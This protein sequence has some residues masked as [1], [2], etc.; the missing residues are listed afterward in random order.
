[1]RRREFL[2]NKMVEV[3]EE[4]GMNYFLL[5]K[6]SNYVIQTHCCEFKVSNHT[7][8][9]YNPFLGGWFEINADTYT[10]DSTYLELFHEIL[11]FL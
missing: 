5:P 1:M 6:E 11:K 8:S 10:D 3:I 4:T 2:V 9:E 7:I